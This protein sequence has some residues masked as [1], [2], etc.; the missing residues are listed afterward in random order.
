MM[1]K[2][3]STMIVL[4]LFALVLVPASARMPVSENPRAQAAPD[5]PKIP[6]VLPAKAS[7]SEQ[8]EKARELKTMAAAIKA[9]GLDEAL[10]NKGPFT[11]FAPS[12]EAFAKLPK[13]EVEA[14]F[15]D[16]ARLRAFVLKHLVSGKMTSR[17]LA[18]ADEVRDVLGAEHAVA[19]KGRTLRVG[20]ARVVR[21][22]LDAT[23]GTIHVIDRVQI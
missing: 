11:L 8:A 19:V 21:G 22:D 7:V 1:K 10:K 23:N 9:A 6:I 3:L 20:E 13:A 14:L 17:D 4:A 15:Q 12:D 18:L 16:Q 5:L 2:L